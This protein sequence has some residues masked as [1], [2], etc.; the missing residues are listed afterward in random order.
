MA[1]DNSYPL[2][3]NYTPMIKV[4]ISI[5]L[6]DIGLPKNYLIFQKATEDS[7]YSGKFSE[8]AKLTE[9]KS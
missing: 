7:V 5:V 9:L 8:K 4:T 3:Q 2:R 6:S 1:W